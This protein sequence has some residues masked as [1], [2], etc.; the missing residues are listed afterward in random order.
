MRWTSIVLVL[1]LAAA[2]CSTG[3]GER[4]G[5]TMQPGPAVPVQVPPENAPSLTNSDAFDTT[6]SPKGAL[7]VMTDLFKELGIEAIAMGP[8]PYGLNA[9]D[10]F[11]AHSTEQTA[12][13]DMIEVRCRWLRDGQTRVLVK[14]NLPAGQQARLVEL[15]RSAMAAAATRPAASTKTQ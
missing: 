2:G 5:S 10:Y 14:S 7:G 3:N 1:S 12:L 13:G 15:L 9:A 8:S 4:S 11:S 6:L